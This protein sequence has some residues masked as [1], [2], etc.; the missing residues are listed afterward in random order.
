[1]VK[2]PEVIIT[3]HE[4][5]PSCQSDHCITYEACL[6]TEKSKQCL[7]NGPAAC[8]GL[9]WTEIYFLILVMFTALDEMLTTLMIL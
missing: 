1:M 4:L 7:F 9:D 3:N 6:L 2:Q 8:T 5:K